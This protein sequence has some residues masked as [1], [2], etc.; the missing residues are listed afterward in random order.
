MKNYLSKVTKIDL[1][2]DCNKNRSILRYLKVKCSLA[3]GYHL[4]LIMHDILCFLCFKTYN[5]HTKCYLEKDGMTYMNMV[6]VLLT[7]FEN[8]A[9]ELYIQEPIWCV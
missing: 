3:L 5:G 8:R 2:V 4:Q 9:S 7:L 6:W 1:K